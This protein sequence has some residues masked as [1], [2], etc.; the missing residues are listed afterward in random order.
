MT[1]DVTKERWYNDPFGWYEEQGHPEIYGVRMNENV[2]LDFLA[3][4]HDIY[5][6]FKKHGADKAIR[7]AE[8]LATLL[9]ASAKNVGS[10]VMD[11]LLAKEFNDIDFD[12]A[13]SD[14]LEGKLDDCE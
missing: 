9:I 12:K 6:S 4:L 10:E 13:M 3:G 5:I 14:L 1:V 7:N 2:A 8:V 11:E